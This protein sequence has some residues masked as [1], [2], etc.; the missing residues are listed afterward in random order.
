MQYNKRMY[1]IQKQLN[2]HEHFTYVCAKITLFTLILTNHFIIMTGNSSYSL[3]TVHEFTRSYQTRSWIIWFTPGLSWCKWE[4]F[5]ISE[6][7]RPTQRQGEQNLHTEALYHPGWGVNYVHRYWNSK[8]FPTWSFLW[9]TW[10][11]IFNFYTLL[12]HTLRYTSSISFNQMKCILRF[13]K[14]HFDKLLHLL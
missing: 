6:F 1:L 4:A 2:M 5:D 9:G 12:L 14:L 13:L 11:L 3:L 8:Q 10:F 7:H